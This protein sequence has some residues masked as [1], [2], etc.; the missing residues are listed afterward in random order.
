[1]NPHYASF[2]LVAAPCTCAISYRL[3]FCIS[4][5]FFLPSITMLFKFESNST[6]S[7][8]PSS[9]LSFSLFTFCS[10]LDYIYWSEIDDSVFFL[11]G[12]NIILVFYFSSS[13]FSCMSIFSCKMLN[14]SLSSL[15]ISPN[16]FLTVAYLTFLLN[17]AYL[18]LPSLYSLIWASSCS[19]LCIWF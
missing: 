15:L 8:R 12:L 4:S 11:M 3:T 17:T 14:W 16:L 18:N 6:P 19:R 7:I 1:M 9:S 10:F 13:F 5:R 2:I